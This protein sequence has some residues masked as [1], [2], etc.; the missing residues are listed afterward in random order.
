MLFGDR[1]DRAALPDSVIKNILGRLH[2][3][4]LF[5]IRALSKEHL[6]ILNRVFSAIHP[7][8]RIRIASVLREPGLWDIGGLEHRRL[9]RI[10]ELYS[11]SPSGPVVVLV[12]VEIAY[13]EDESTHSCPRPD[14]IAVLTDGFLSRG[15]DV[16]LYIRPRCFVQRG[17]EFREL[18]RFSRLASLVSVSVEAGPLKIWQIEALRKVSRL[19]T[20]KRLCLMGVAVPLADESSADESSVDESSGK[21]KKKKAKD[22]SNEIR[23]LLLGLPGL[24]DLSLASTGLVI[25]PLVPALSLMT[26]MESL[27]LRKTHVDPKEAA[28]V[29]SCMPGLRSLALS[30]IHGA[31]TPGLASVIFSLSLTKL[32]LNRCGITDARV[33]SSA[34]VSGRSTIETLDLSENRLSSVDGISALL[35]ALPLLREMDL[36]ETLADHDELVPVLVAH[37]SVKTTLTF[38]FRGRLAD[39][40]DRRS[41][42]LPGHILWFPVDHYQP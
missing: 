32:S 29:I 3:H 26:R 28:D 7:R 35:D 21:K 2:V 33:L 18:S 6:E 20:L 40:D 37:P 12:Y 24:V 25:G 31:F 34:A 42:E 36:Q 22:G 16:H 9:N 1:A 23:R 14:Q 8:R 17:R 13:L 11:G 19:A 10:R 30:W 5:A 38:P 39:H 41:I 27:D 15:D 4:D